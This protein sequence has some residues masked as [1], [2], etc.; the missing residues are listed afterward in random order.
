MRRS[1]IENSK[2]LVFYNFVG[3][4]MKFQFFD[5]TKAVFHDQC[6]VYDFQSSNDKTK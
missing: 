2:L 5:F 4:S 6:F 1:N 3:T